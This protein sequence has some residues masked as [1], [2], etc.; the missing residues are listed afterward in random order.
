MSKSIKVNVKAM[1]IMALLVALNI[2]LSQTLTIHTW[3]LKIGFNFI[4]VVVAAMMYGPFAAGLVGALGDIVSAVAFPVGPYF[5]GFTLTAAITGIVFGLFLKKKPTIV[6][7]VL[8]VLI[9]QLIIGWFGNTY[10]IHVLYGSPY[11]A[12][13]IS[14]IPQCLG[15]S[16]VQ[17]ACIIAMN[18]KLIP[19]LKRVSE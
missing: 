10:F 4:P 9:V 15:M 6:K 3:N 12:L 13:F 14:R 16:V 19:V 1:S 8:S 18:S 11:K 7:I 5:P 17:I 2:V